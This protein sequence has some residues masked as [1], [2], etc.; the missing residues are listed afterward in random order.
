MTSSYSQYVS[1]EI[2]EKTLEKADTLLKHMNIL[3]RYLVDDYSNKPSC[4]ILYSRTSL[5][6]FD[7]IGSGEQ[8]DIIIIIESLN[9]M[10]SFEFEFMS[11]I[12]PNT[13]KATNI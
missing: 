3:I 8:L 2:I 9:L 10:H 6:D 1:D 4:K 12:L 7:K 5:L 13:L 11:P